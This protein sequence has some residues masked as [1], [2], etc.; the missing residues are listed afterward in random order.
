MKKT[1]EARKRALPEGWEE[2]GRVAI[3]WQNGIGFCERHDA[4]RRAKRGQRTV[5]AERTAESA[6]AIIP[7]GEPLPSAAPPPEALA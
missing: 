7:P 3:T 6:T 5:A 1:C 2:C 4:E